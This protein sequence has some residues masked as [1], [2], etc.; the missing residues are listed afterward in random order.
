[1]INDYI[2]GADTDH[3]DAEDCF[4]DVAPRVKEV[5]RETQV[6]AA[7]EIVRQAQASRLPAPFLRVEPSTGDVG[8]VSMEDVLGELLGVIEEE[9]GEEDSKPAPFTP[10]DS[11]EFPVTQKLHRKFKAA[12]PSPKIMRVDTEESYKK[13]MDGKRAP[14]IEELEQRVARAEAA[15]AQHASD[16][17]GVPIYVLGAD[18]EHAKQRAQVCGDEIP[19]SLPPGTEK[20]VKVWQD[21]NQICCSMRLPGP[22]GKARIATSSSPVE[23]HVEEVLGYMDDAGVDPMEVKD[24]LPLLAQIL[25]GGALITQIAAAAPELLSRPEVHAGKPF[26]GKV[27]PVS[28]PAVAAIMALLQMCQ[29]GDKYALKEVKKLR[30]MRGS[31]ALFAAAENGFAEANKS[32]SK[33]GV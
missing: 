15:L 23:R 19:M 32:R 25:G 1:M 8:D 29:K 22:D 28:D 31:D 6:A 18:V 13:F 3:Y 7:R 27:T 21:G 5:S 9:D 26:V 20:H 33:G 16:G 30:A 12:M 10:V 2:L 4:D 24:S 14:Y 11:P 17:H